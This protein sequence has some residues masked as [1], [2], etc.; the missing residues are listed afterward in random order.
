MKEV[1][2]GQALT[3]Y[4]Q[5]D[6]IFAEEIK[7]LAPHWFVDTAAE[8]KKI[9]LEMAKK[10][11]QKP[12]RDNKYGK[13]LHHYIGQNERTYDPVFT[14]EIKK[15]APNWFIDTAAENKEILLEM[16]KSGETRPNV[17]G[18]LGSALH[19][20]NGSGKSSYDPVFDAEIR[21]LAPHWFKER[22]P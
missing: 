5:K 6:P 15:L 22:T 18:K 20:Y 13:V 11:E 21:K 14:A 8:N 3:N 4:L 10:G 7:R 17:K 16:A 9:L 19:H 12:L 2:F 1:D